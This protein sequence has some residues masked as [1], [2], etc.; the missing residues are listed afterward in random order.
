MSASIPTGSQAA[1]AERRRRI[2]ATIRADP[3]LTMEQIRE[4]WSLSARW[5]REL[6]YEARWEAA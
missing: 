1:A 2:V 5:A 6:I 3:E 4:R